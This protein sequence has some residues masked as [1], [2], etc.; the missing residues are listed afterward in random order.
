ME[1]LEV[2]DWWWNRGKEGGCSSFGGEPSH[3]VKGVSGLS[4]RLVLERGQ[5]G[6]F[7][8]PA[9]PALAAPGAPLVL[10]VVGVEI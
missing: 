5:F 9:W 4:R 7:C 2:Y 8:A 6:S 1:G 3:W 10:L